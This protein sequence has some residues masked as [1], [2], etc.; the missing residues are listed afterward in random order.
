MIDPSRLVFDEKEHRFFL[1]GEELPGVTRILA[2]MGCYVV[3]YNATEFHRD[4]GSA[5]H[6][7]T[8]YVDAGAWDPEQTAISVGGVRNEAETHKLRGFI[9]SYEKFVAETGFVA[10]MVETRVV[11]ERYRFAGILD[12]YGVAGPERGF[13]R[14][15]IDL[16]A[17]A[18]AP[19]HHLQTALYKVALSEMYGKETDETFV[20][21][22]DPDGDLGRLRSGNGND[23]QRAL[24]AVN[25]FHWRKKWGLLK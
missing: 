7:G 20:L 8:A 17:G 16:K 3:P 23:V 12:K 4:R 6:L 21:Q 19:G 10:E 9:R 15:L 24:E 5:V 2:A 14:W 22:L 25:L 13:R 18:I 11:S 1:D